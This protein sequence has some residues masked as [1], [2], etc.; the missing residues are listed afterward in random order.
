M[1]SLQGIRNSTRKRPPP[2]S[3]SSRTPDAH[4]DDSTARPPKRAKRGVAAVLNA[5]VAQSVFGSAKP[6]S[7]AKALRSA[8]RLL[9]KEGGVDEAVRARKEVEIKILTAQLA[10]KQRHDRINKVDKKYKMIKFIGRPLRHP[11]H[12]RCMWVMLLLLLYSSLTVGCVARCCCCCVRRATEGAASSAVF[13]AAAD[14]DDGR[15]EG[16]E[17]GGEARARRAGEGA[18]GPG[19]HR[20]LPQGHQVHRTLPLTRLHHLFRL[21]L[22]ASEAQWRRRPRR[23]GRGGRA[24]VRRRGGASAEG[25]SPGRPTTTEGGG[26]GSAGGGVASRRATAAGAG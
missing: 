10:D 1:A 20:L 16:G 19:L 4:A 7:L 26:G 3:S 11:P 24:C 2:P 9:S 22:P 18:E 6:V 25:G 13:A 5:T 14:A 21:S 15:G 8:R 17:R 23:R 12:T